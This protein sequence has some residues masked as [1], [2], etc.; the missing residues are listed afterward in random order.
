LGDHLLTFECE[1]LDG[2]IDTSQR[3]VRVQ[4]K[5]PLAV[6]NLSSI[7]TTITGIDIDHLGHVLVRESSG[8][9]HQ[10][11]FHY[12]NVLVDFENKELIFRDKYD[13]V[14]VIK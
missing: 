1:Y 8:K 4:A 2:V 7:S 13:E 14:K 11:Q 5:I 3:L 10:L 12:D 9:V 6:I